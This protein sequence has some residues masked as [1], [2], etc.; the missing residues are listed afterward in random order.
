MIVVSEALYQQVEYLLDQSLAGNHVLFEQQ[1][2]RDVFCSDLGKNLTEEQSVAVEHHIE[3]LI[4]QPT[5]L[6]KRA[7][8][9]GLDPATYRLVVRTYFN[10]IENRLLE[11][12][13]AR[14]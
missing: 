6:Q 8:L 2:I 5:L 4:E 12:I 14:H 3:R 13:Q 11:N 9:E 7:Y 1:S 10:I